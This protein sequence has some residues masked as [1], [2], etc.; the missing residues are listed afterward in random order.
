MSKPDP[1]CIH[2]QAH[3]GKAYRR[4]LSPSTW[5][6]E[7]GRSHQA[8]RTKERVA[9]RWAPNPGRF[10]SSEGQKHR[11]QSST[12]MLI[13][14]SYFTSQH[15]SKEKS[16]KNFKLVTAEH[17]TQGQGSSELG[18]MWLHWLHAHKAGFPGSQPT[19][20]WEACRWEGKK[21]QQQKPVKEGGFKKT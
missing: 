19:G 16:I 6:A 8:R 3:T 17:E 9:D 2:T 12:S 4:P 20:T 15:K 21:K 11:S 5:R 18:L 14:H 1:L 13:I 10:G 7:S